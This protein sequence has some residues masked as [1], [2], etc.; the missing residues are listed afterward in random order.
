[1]GFPGKYKAKL[2]FVIKEGIQAVYA[3]ILGQMVVIC[4]AV[5]AGFCRLGICKQLHSSLV[6]LERRQRIEN[7][8]ADTDQLVQ[9]KV[10]KTLTVFG[11]GKGNHTA[12][13]L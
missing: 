1:M 7:T 10:L 2:F 4:R 12:A 3:E 13:V 9:V 5:Y 11:N 8:G 6:L